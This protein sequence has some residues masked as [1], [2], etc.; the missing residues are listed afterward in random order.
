MN[1]TLNWNAMPPLNRYTFLTGNPQYLN[2]T[3]AYKA[4]ENGK[5]IE[6]EYPDTK[7]Q[8]SFYYWKDNSIYQA[9]PAELHYMG[10]PGGPQDSVYE[11]A[12][13]HYEDQL[14]IIV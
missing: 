12:I 5:V 2:G 3:M 9:R 10:T 11:N 14:L 6:V 13:P 4:I 8:A 7:L 1:R